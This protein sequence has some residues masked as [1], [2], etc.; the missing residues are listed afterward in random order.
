MFEMLNLVKPAEPSPTFQ[1]RR[2]NIQTL[3]S[4]SPSHPFCPK[5][6]THSPSYPCVLYCP[7]LLGWYGIWQ[8][9][10]FICPT[11]LLPRRGR[12]WHGRTR[13][14]ECF[15]HHYGCWRSKLLRMKGCSMRERWW[16]STGCGVGYW[17]AGWEGKHV[18]CCSYPR[19]RCVCMETF[20]WGEGGRQAGGWCASLV[21][22]L[23]MGGIGA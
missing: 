18:G 16:L 13:A 8:A 15:L 11:G 20:C 12:I 2:G 3:F 19:C 9:P 4:L 5:H 1:P 7:L 10:A 14:G 22:L 17:G 6:C 21:C 23:L